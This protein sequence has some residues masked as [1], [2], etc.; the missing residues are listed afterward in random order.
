MQQKPKVPPTP[1]GLVA[2]A[3]SLAEALDLCSLQR[4]NKSSSSQSGAAISFRLRLLYGKS[5]CFLITLSRRAKSKGLA[6]WA[7]KP[8]FSYNSISCFMALAVN[9]MRGKD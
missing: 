1:M 4:G 3:L 9:A 5:R 6:T 2:T 7:A 8:S